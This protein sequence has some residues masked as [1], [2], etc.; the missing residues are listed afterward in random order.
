MGHPSYDASTIEA[1][2]QQYWQKEQCFKT[3][4]DA[5]REKFYCLTMFP[6]PSGQL[7]M[8]HVRNYT[9]GDVIARYQHMLGKNV[10]QPIGWDAFGLPA[11]NA[12]LKHQVAASTWTKQNIDHMRL[13]LKHLGMAYDWDRE[14]AT[15]DPEY[16]RWEQWLFIQLFKRGLVYKK[17]SV[18]NWDPVDQTVLA[19]EQV[20][21]GRGWRSD[22]LIER[23]EISQWFLKIT[24][25]AEELL[26]D[27][28]K[29]SGW[30]QEVRTMQQHWI[31]RSEGAEIHFDVENSTEIL[32][33]FSTRLDTLAGVTYLAIAATHPLASAL[34]KDNAALQAFQKE[35]AHL[36][37][38][39][40]QLA[41][42]EKKGMF[43]GLYAHHPL[44]G[45]RLPIWLANFVLM[46]YGSG[47][48]MAVPA[49]DQRDFEFAQKYNLPIRAVIKPKDGSDWDFKERAFTPYGTVVAPPSCAGLSS[50][51]AFHQL[52]TELTPLG[53]VSAKIHYRLRDWGISRQRYWGAPIPMI[54]CPH[55]G[56]VP[57]A[58]K[59]LPVIL[60]AHITLTKP[61]SPLKDL[62]EFLETTCPKCH[63]PAQRETDTFDTFVES[64]WYYARYASYN[65]HN[66]MLDDRV[67]Y[68][69][70]VDQYVGGIEHAILHLLYARFFHKVMRDLGLVHSDEPFSRLLTQG[71]V[72]KD[73]AKMSK[74]KG[75]V[76]DPK[77]LM[78]KYGADTVRLFIIF[79]APPATSLE[80]SDSG[81]AG[82]HRFLH[83]LW[84]YC[85]QQKSVSI[86]QVLDWHSAD[87]SVQSKR[88]ELHLILQQINNDYERQQFNTV[89]S[90]A[91]KIL[92]LLEKELP[93]AQQAAEKALL[94]EG[95]SIILRVLAP[96][97]P[98][99]THVLWQELGYGQDILQSPWP[100]LS[101]EA[102]ECDE[103][104]L[105]IQINGK[106]RG[107]LNVA[108]D[109]TE[110]HIKDMAV[111]DPSLQ[112]HLQGQTIKK[113]IYIPRRLINIV[114][115]A[116]H[117]A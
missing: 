5:N 43:S 38:A 73:G 54:N 15:C 49:H 22:A 113:I 12:A 37:V 109:S 90:G 64:S 14:L 30:P 77:G 58:E 2:V 23:K 9:L 68:W 67:N 6:Y 31:G 57:V 86:E 105:V 79:A 56:S 101:L 98:H 92:N 19:N 75:N 84:D 70:P 29:L 89:V 95:L 80:W 55:C 13:Q 74:S 87:K 52:L 60:P 7:H 27:L 40:A 94:H 36:Q 62:P 111:N 116:P 69:T 106:L 112:H 26:C 83:R 99:I 53:K 18:V 59:D 44:T 88:R 42:V 39:E 25:Y 61:Q 107:N 93:S 71:M 91:M 85:Q 11:E 50:E 104:E 41:T 76:V 81:V 108:S 3:I 16:Y 97:V 65:Q 10:L 63:T 82:S 35:C 47:A 24:D 33:V 96:I 72:L 103:M 28:D 20:I 8:G 78:E 102:L 21:D 115:G 46:E 17:K 34:A 66:A 4:E 110:A 48:V 32:T 1:K 114:L 51:Q 117:D 45:E 100:K